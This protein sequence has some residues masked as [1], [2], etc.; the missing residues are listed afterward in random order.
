[1]KILMELLIYSVVKVGL[2]GITW[3]ALG[4]TRRNIA[5]HIEMLKR[6]PS[7][8]KRRR[9]TN[10]TVR[11]KIVKII[12]AS[13]LIPVIGEV[14]LVAITIGRFSN[15][16]KIAKI[17]E[18]ALMK[19][20]TDNL[21]DALNKI[22]DTNLSLY[23][24]LKRDAGC[25]SAQGHSEI[26]NQSVLAL[27]SLLIDANIAGINIKSEPSIR[28]AIND[29][30]RLVS[31]LLKEEQ[32]GIQSSIDKYL[33]VIDNIKSDLIGKKAVFMETALT[34]SRDKKDNL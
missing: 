21:N 3:P 9:T 32:S 27:N 12:P 28:D 6:V 7:T 29:T 13:I 30:T 1:V 14:A 8:H 15:K 19:I 11:Q 24:N 31:A 18:G 25:L 16:S 2:A 20:D 22:G 33:N 23:R 10:L 5:T 34:E 4:P 26:A 17:Y